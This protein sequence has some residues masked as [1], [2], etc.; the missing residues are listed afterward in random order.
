MIA[1]YSQL[2]W[3]PVYKLIALS[4]FIYHFHQNDSL[5]VTQCR[6]KRRSVIKLQYYT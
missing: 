1:D 2:A 3:N 6:I 4:P 5:Y